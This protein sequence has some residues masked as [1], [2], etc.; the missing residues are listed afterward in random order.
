MLTLGG[1]IVKAMSFEIQ[2]VLTH[3]RAPIEGIYASLAQHV[4]LPNAPNAEEFKPAFRESY[5]KTMK[6]FPCYRYPN[7]P[8]LWSS[9][10]WWRKLCAEVLLATN[11][12]YSEAEV[13]RFFRAVY[14]HYGGPAGY[15]VFPDAAD[16]LKWLADLPKTGTPPSLG[17]TSN[18]STR[19]IDTTL[20][21]LGLSQQMHFFTCSQEVGVDKPSLQMFAATLRAI[22]HH[23]PSIQKNEVLHIGTK[24][25]YVAARQFG[26]QAL[27]LDRSHDSRVIPRAVEPANE[28][29]EGEGDDLHLEY[30]LQTNTIKDLAALRQLLQVA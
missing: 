10:R 4:G 30:H 29:F 8:A 28:G 18:C 7:D 19:T 13:D 3:H 12:N 1:K 5:A 2:G 25:D 22:Q 24:S 9:R 11:R 6:D 21:V 14:Q 27:F 15:A 17:V 23:S 26:F 20:P 16:L